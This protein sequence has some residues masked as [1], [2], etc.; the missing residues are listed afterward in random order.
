MN[1]RVLSQLQLMQEIG[2]LKW[3]LVIRDSHDNGEWENTTQ[4]VAHMIQDK[5]D[6]LD[7]LRMID[8]REVTVEAFQRYAD[9]LTEISYENLNNQRG[10]TILIDWEDENDEVFGDEESL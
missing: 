1:S 3:Q 8:D 5:E 4:A 7:V 10:L 9:Y 6:T 2:D